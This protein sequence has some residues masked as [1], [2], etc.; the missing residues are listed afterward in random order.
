MTDAEKLAAKAA[1]LDAAVADLRRVVRQNGAPIGPDADIQTVAQHALNISVGQSVARWKD[2]AVLDKI[3][4]ILYLQTGLTTPDL[5]T[6]ELMERPIEDAALIA[7]RRSWAVLRVTKQGTEIVT[8]GGSYYQQYLP[9]VTY[10]EVTEEVTDL[11]TG[12]VTT[13]T[14]TVAN[15][16]ETEFTRGGESEWL[17]TKL[18]QA[19]YDLTRQAWHADIHSGL[20]TYTEG[21]MDYYVIP[22]ALPVNLEQLYELQICCGDAATKKKLNRA[23]CDITTPGIIGMPEG[24]W[25]IYDNSELVSAPMGLL[26]PAEM[27]DSSKQAKPWTSLTVIHSPETDPLSC[28]RLTGDG[29]GEVYI[30]STQDLGDNME[31]TWTE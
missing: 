4:S 22:C 16:S 30:I 19:A 8:Y 31:G 13:V 28:L 7:D 17:L 9:V 12:A 27:C 10:E 2:I 1:L 24:I 20:E 6:A 14:N 21:G 5:T 29:F 26:V 18:R 11:D 25:Y 23:V 15:I 3:K